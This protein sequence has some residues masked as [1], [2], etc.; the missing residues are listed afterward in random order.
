MRREQG[1]AETYSAGFDG[2]MY[3]VELTPK[4]GRLIGADKAPLALMLN[5]GWLLSDDWREDTR[6]L[7]WLAMAEWA[8]RHSFAN[9]EPAI[10]RISS[11]LHS[12]NRQRLE[13]IYMN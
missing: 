3:E 8:A 4:T 1:E 11:P 12:E 6:I 13:P 9:A 2:R 5:L 10:F 7:H